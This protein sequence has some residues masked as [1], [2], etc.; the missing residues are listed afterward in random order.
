MSRNTKSV[1]VAFEDQYL[2]GGEMTGYS[3]D[4]TTLGAT[5]AAAGT[6]TTLTA[7]GKFGCNGQTAVSAAATVAVIS[8]VAQN[9]GFGFSTSAQLIA[10]QAAINSIL[11]CLKSAG[12]MAS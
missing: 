5:T 10:A 7:T 8:T 3:V 4:N 12:L 11:A 2:S 9:S 1:G 6:F